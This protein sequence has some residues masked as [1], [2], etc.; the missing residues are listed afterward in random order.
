MLWL[1]RIFARGART[2]RD[3]FQV[4]FT[5]ALYW[6]TVVPRAFLQVIFFL[7][8]A[9]YAGGIELARF[10]YLGN[11]TQIAVGAV[12]TSLAFVLEF[13]RSTGNLTMWHC[14]PAPRPLVL[15]SRCTAYVIDAFAT[16]LLV[17]FAIGPVITG[18]FR[19]WLELIVVAPVLILIT[20]SVSGLA[21]L[22]S[23]VS[24]S[25]RAEINLP[26]GVGYAMMTRCGVTF[27]ATILPAPLQA[28][29]NL[30]P[31]TNGLKAARQVAAT[32]SY[33]G[34][35]R[36][37]LTEVLIGIVYAIVGLMVFELLL[38]RARRL[39]TTDLN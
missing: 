9:Y 21:V 19:V 17:A 31:L 16:S 11:T 15:L 35:G 6:G 22:V 25:L 12:L 20:L 23:A 32:M 28:L 14:L 18:G 10:A 24:L 27:P 3:M 2:S 5:P 30:L 8:L 33:M 4:Q 29:G 1:L 26:F 37:L 7:M 13:E 38:S 34:S 36:Y 39:G